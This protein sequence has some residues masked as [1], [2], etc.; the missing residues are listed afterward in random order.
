MFKL[1]IRTSNLHTPC[2]KHTKSYVN[3]YQECILILIFTN[4]AK[5]HAQVSKCVLIT[6]IVGPLCKL[7]PFRVQL[8][9]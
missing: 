6:Q 1:S 8:T 4:C 2:E 7:S 3:T 5:T 9:M